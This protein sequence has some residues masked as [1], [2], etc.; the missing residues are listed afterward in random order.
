MAD[1]LK[2]LAPESS[3][4]TPAGADR[5]LAIRSLSQPFRV[6]ASNLLT[7]HSQVRSGGLA[8]P[9]P[10]YRPHRIIQSMHLLIPFAAALSDAAM[11]DRKSVV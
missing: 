3:S 5:D 8:Q 11:Q 6:K 9:R 7:L 10:S 4:G 1:G 2:S